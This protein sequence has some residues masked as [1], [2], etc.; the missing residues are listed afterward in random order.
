[1]N[2]YIERKLEE[3]EKRA[4]DPDATWIPHDEFWDKVRTL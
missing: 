1:M 2:L 4:S 3:A